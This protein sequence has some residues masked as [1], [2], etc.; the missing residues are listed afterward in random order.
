MARS[1][2]PFAVFLFLAAGLAIAAC[3]GGEKAPP[4]PSE[5]CVSDASMEGQ[6]SDTQL[7]PDGPPSFPYI[8]E[9]NFT[10]DGK[11]GPANL[12]MQARIGV[13]K[14]DLI[15]TGPGTYRNIILGPITQEDLEASVEFYL[16][17]PEQGGVKAD[18]T[19]SFRKVNQPTTF[20]CDLSFPR[21]P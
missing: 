2:R 15:H 18:Q 14:S 4:H 1:L 12:P 19:F 3:S 17:D 6:Q 5:V 7:P 11:S 20:E 8:F 10:V 9:G 16:G 21:L 13:G